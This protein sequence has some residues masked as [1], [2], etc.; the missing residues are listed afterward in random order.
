MHNLNARLEA[1]GAYIKECFLGKAT[2]LFAYIYGGISVHG[3]S[4]Q[5]GKR[6]YFMD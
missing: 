5:G 6:G 1:V 3:Y 4:H 2:V